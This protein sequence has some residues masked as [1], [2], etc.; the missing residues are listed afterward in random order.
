MNKFSHFVVYS[1]AATAIAALLCMA[2][3]GYT[4][5]QDGTGGILTYMNLLLYLAFG[6]LIGCYGDRLTMGNR[7]VTLPATLFFMGCAVNPQLAPWQEG[8]IYL[9]LMAG[10]YHIL[11]DTY[12]SNTAMGSYFTAFCLVGIA[13]LHCPQLLYAAPVLI[14]CS[15]FM[16]SLHIRTIL[17]ALFGILMPYWTAFCILFVTDNTH[18]IQPF[19]SELTMGITQTSA[20]IHIPLGENNT[21]AVPMIIVQLIWT[22]LL[23]VPATVHHILSTTS[24]VRTRTNRYMQIGYMTTLLAATLLLPSLYTAL[25]PVVVALTAIL[26]YDFFTV[27]RKGRNIWFITLFCIWLLILG[28]YVW[29]SYLIY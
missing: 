5:I 8:T 12:R 20:L 22:L 15:G 29:N 28:L 1:W 23:I 14:L 6:V 18:L 11:L 9:I 27:G 7:K 25:Q 13:S 10:A 24:K 16:Q 17:A 21:V 2:I 19:V 4:I 3:W 26:S